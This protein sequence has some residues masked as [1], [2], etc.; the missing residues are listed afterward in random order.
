MKIKM[1]KDKIFK[2]NE[3]KFT[4]GAISDIHLTD[5][6]DDSEEKLRGAL[7]TLSDFSENGLDAV[8]CVGD[9][10]DSRKE[11]QIEKFKTIYE[12]EL[13]LSVPLVYCLGDGHDQR[14]T[15]DDDAPQTF[16]RIFGGEVFKADVEKDIIKNV[17][18]PS[19][20]ASKYIKQLLA[21]HMEK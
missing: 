16:A 2:E 14:W 17:Y 13:S 6:G 10:I 1:K 15:A 4:F 8:L 18:A 11:S 3:I 21:E 9:L 5:G 12:E 19:I 20:R 7:Q